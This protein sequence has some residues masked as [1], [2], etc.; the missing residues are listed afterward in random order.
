[1]AKVYTILQDGED[2]GEWFYA[3][4][5]ANSVVTGRNYAGDD[6]EP[7]VTWSVGER[8]EAEAYE[9]DEENDGETP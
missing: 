6:A 3:F 7:S 4:G 5:Q 2:T 1:M 9:L 8:D